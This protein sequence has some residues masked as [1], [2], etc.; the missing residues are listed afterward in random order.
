MLLA[1]ALPACI[2][3]EQAITSLLLVAQNLSLEILCNS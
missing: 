2:A 1:M 3:I